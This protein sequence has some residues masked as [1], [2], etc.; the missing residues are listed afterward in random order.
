MSW[1][2]HKLLLLCASVVLA[3]PAAGAA[4]E[5]LQTEEAQ[6]IEEAAVSNGDDEPVDTLVPT[7]HEVDVDALVPVDEEELPEDAVILEL[8]EVQWQALLRNPS[9]HAAEARIAQAQ[10]RVNQVRALY[11]PQVDASYSATHTRLPRTEVRAQRQAISR[12]LQQGLQSTLG[13]VLQGNPVTGDTL[14]GLGQSWYETQRARDAVPTSVDTYRASLVASYLVFDG[15]ARRFTKAIAEFGYEQ[16]EA[17]YSESQRLLLAAVAQ[18][19]FGAQ[20]ARENIAIARA[21]ETFNERLLREAEARRRVGTGPL[22]DVL[23]FEVQMRA[24]RTAVLQSQNQYEQARIALA[25]L[26]GL[27]EARLEDNVVVGELLPELPEELVRPEEEEL[28]QFAL[29]F[30][31]DLEASMLGVEQAD[32]I[33]GQRRAA[34]YPRIVASAAHEATVSSNTRFD[35]G[36]FAT[37]ISLGLSYNLFAGGQRKAE[38][39]E[40]RHIHTEARHQLTQAEIDITT[41]VRQAAEELRS[42]Q[43]Q[44]VLQRTTA[45]YVER[46]RDL[47]EHEL[48]AGQ[49]P[50]TRLNQAQRDLIAAQARLALARVSLRLAWHDLD[51]ATASILVRFNGVPEEAEEA[52]EAVEED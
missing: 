32:A 23:N 34:F 21:D 22:S 10:E 37:S 46:N 29:A 20:L 11:Y 18:T 14:V 27:P 17:A 6:S 13:G 7:E 5:P 47:V 52:A 9:L 39:A 40:A 26:M 1:G 35:R 19:F 33:I 50:V 28:I 43:E 44:L 31:P 48:R 12:G 8:E 15:F 2:C 45:E 42:A 38:V 36:D 51:V 24:A 30:R 41:E 49:A 25:A 16:S 3:V 4:A